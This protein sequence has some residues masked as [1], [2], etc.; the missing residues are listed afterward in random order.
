VT[1]VSVVIVTLNEEAEIEPC[2][3]SVSWADEVI[4]VDAFSSDRTVEIARKYTD[5]VILRNWA[6]YADQ[7]NWAV[8][9][10]R[11]DWVLSLD[12]DERITLQLRDEISKILKSGPSCSGYYIPRKNFFLGRWIRH[13]GWFP[14]YTLRL[15]EKK[16]GRFGD[17][18]VHESVRVNGATKRL[19]NPIEHYT[20][21]SLASYH[22]RASRYS[23][24][25]AYEM[26]EQGKRFHLMDLC[27]RP[28]WT[29]LRMYLIRQGFRDGSDGLILAVFY[30][31]YTFLKYAKLWEMEKKA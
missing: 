6:G 17:R 14:D 18:A 9:Q 15:F 16:M 7:K 22:A 26:R 8:G 3:E 5:K 31:Y 19:T 13:G 28:V 12:A 27:L 2:L 4:V 23:A 20:Y 30:G 25:A 29:F 21:R 24:L 1:K 11:Y 10:S